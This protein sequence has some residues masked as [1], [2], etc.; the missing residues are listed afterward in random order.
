[1]VRLF[2]AGI[3]LCLSSVSNGQTDKESFV[4]CAEG[5]A[6]QDCNHI[7]EA[8]DR[9]NVVEGDVVSLGSR[10]QALESTSGNLPAEIAAITAEQILQNERLDSISKITSVNRD[11]LD[12]ALHHIFTCGQYKLF[13]CNQATSSNGTVYQL[14]YISQYDVLLMYEESAP[15][16]GDAVFFAIPESIFNYSNLWIGGTSNLTRPHNPGSGLVLVDDCNNPTIELVLA[17]QPP[18]SRLVTNNGNYYRARID[19]SGN[20]EF[21]YGPIIET[22]NVT[23]GTYGL[24]NLQTPGNISDACTLV[25]DRTGLYDAYAIELKFNIYDGRFNS[26]WTFQ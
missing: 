10:V 15:N 13:G 26:P 23:G 18:S 24:I 5:F 21:G 2:V 8:N 19:P 3:L 6:S 9:F 25:N 7:N 14:S 22:V 1:M 12:A 20:S 11:D 16:I 4:A 17:G